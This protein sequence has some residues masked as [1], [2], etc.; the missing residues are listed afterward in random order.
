MSS[1]PKRKSK[2]PSHR[3]TMSHGRQQDVLASV[4]KRLKAG[5]P[6]AMGHAER[7]HKMPLESVREVEYNGHH[8]IIHTQYKIKVDGKSL[9]GHIYVDNSGRVST[10]AL[11][12]YSFTSTVDLVKKLID[13]FPANFAKASRQVSTRQRKRR[14]R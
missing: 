12:N 2:K 1:R 14:I 4:Y 3:N 13:A 10:H 7:H 5:K 11:P 6:V 9:S 8:I